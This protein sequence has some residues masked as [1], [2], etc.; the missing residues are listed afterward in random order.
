M[1]MKRNFPDRLT[2][3]VNSV[4]FLAGLILA[5]FSTQ[6]VLAK[7][8]LN[9]IP[10]VALK[11][12]SGSVGPKQVWTSQSLGSLDFADKSRQTQ[13]YLYDFQ[14]E[15]PYDYTVVNLFEWL[16]ALSRPA[17]VNTANLIFANGMIIPMPLNSSQGP[18]VWL[19]WSYR[20][21]ANKPWNREFPLVEKKSEEWRDPRPIRFLGNK[22]I[23]SNQRFFPRPQWEVSDD[24]SPFKHADSLLRIE[25]V[26]YQEW[27]QQFN[28]SQSAA[29]LRGQKVFTSRC[30]FCHAIWGRGSKYGWDFVDPLPLYEKR[31]AQSLLFHVKYPKNHALERGLM[32]PEQTGIT[33]E[34]A[35][36]LWIWMR[37]AAMQKPRL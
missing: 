14:Y 34:E 13:R 32:M 24:F 28:V 33:P 26:D 35:E 9:K 18:L 11:A 37:D 8:S 27:N 15:K 2:Q 17:H 25:L 21:Q 19:A 4:F 22:V 36:D 16:M 12:G 20:E 5:S 31:Q 7:E 23:V 30:Q 3:K 6:S 1:D 10:L 29:G